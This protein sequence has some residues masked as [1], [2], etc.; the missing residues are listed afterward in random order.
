MN[1]NTELLNYIYQNAEMGTK[2]ISQLLDIVEDSAFKAQL[3]AQYEEYR[4]MRQAAQDKLQACGYDEKGISAF[5]TLRS[6]LMIGVQTLGDKSASHVAE[7][8]II[9]SNMGVIEAIKKLK[10]YSGAEPEIIQL[11]EHLK[12][13]EENNIQSL[14]AYL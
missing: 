7:M 4:R 9:G 10:Q 1:G 14:K 2:T 5:D 11:M 8:M 12:T 3:Q 13:V 6:Y